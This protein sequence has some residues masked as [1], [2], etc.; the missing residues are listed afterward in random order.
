[1]QAKFSQGQLLA[2]A[3][4]NERQADLWKGNS[5]YAETLRMEAWALRT[6]A[7]L[8]APETEDWFAGTRLEAGHQ[9]LRYAAGHDAGKSAFDWF[10][11]IGYLAQKAAAA[12]L[13]GDIEKAKHHT[14]STAAALLNWHRKLSGAA[15]EMRPG[16]DLVE[17]EIEIAGESQL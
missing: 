5:G 1:M 13:I 8:F 4:F 12:E 15:G 10:W 9:N 2:R 3:E 17:R 16:I 11:L 7:T 14:I 6:A